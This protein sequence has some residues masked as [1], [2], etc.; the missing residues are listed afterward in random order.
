[1]TVFTSGTPQVH[2]TSVIHLRYSFYYFDWNLQ[3]ETILTRLTVCATSI[4]V[5]YP[6][7]PTV[8]DPITKMEV[9]YTVGPCLFALSI[10]NG[11]SLSNQ[12]QGDQY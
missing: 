7:T 4:T 9:A 2:Y 1:M 12:T 5:I 3:F 11:L 6:V 8:M 10:L